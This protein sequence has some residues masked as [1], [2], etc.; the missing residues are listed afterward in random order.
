[1]VTRRLARQI[2]PEDL[3][4]DLARPIG[5]PVKARKLTHRQAA[6]LKR[7][8]LEKYRV[9][10]NI[11]HCARLVGIDR[12]DIYYWQEHDETFAAAFQL[13]ESDAIETM[14]REA[15]RRGIEGSPYERT[16]YWKG[17][18]VGTD[19]KIEYSDNLLLALLK[20]KAP[21]RYRDKV[22]LHANVIIKTVAGV[23]PSEVL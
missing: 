17:E 15:W 4:E 22:D 5:E 1:M 9:Y 10:G 12:R 6:R 20:A 2:R 8:F 11:S 18:P 19:R 16:S 3:P 14:E 7:A 21:E 13:A 23:N